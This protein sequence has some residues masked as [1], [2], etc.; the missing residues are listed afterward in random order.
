MRFWEVSR[1]SLVLF[2]AVKATG[3]EDRCGRRWDMGWADMVSHVVEKAPFVA[4]LFPS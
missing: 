4:S 1:V 2:V 3:A